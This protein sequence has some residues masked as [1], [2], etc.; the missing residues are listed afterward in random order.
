MAVK[1]F[2]THVDLNGNEL[3]NALPETVA[4]LPPATAENAGL[5]LRLGSDGLL[6]GSTGTE[7]QGL[8]AGAAAP[9]AYMHMQAVPQSVVTVA[10]GLGYR[11]TV[12]MFSP[13]FSVQYV[14]FAVEHLDINTVRVAM[15]TPH[16]CALVMS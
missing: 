3:R 1:H 2:A 6:Y 8:M 11:P 5:V 13:D 4:A 16:T 15:D 10:H 9:S 14:G 7:W 12:T